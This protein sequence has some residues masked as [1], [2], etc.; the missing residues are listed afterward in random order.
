MN[1]EFISALHEIEKE[2]GISVD[3][4]IEALEAAL[5]SAYKKNFSTPQGVRV[6]IDRHKGDI[7]V[8]AQTQIVEEVSDERMEIS[9]EEAQKIDPNYQLGDVLENEVTPGDFGRIAAQTAKQVVVQRIREAERNIVYEDFMNRTSDII[10]GIVRRLENGNVFIDFGKAEGMLPLAEQINKERYHIGE[11]IKVYIVDVKKTNKGPQIIISRTHPGLIKRLFELEVPEIHDGTVEV[12]SVSREPGARSKIAVYAENENVDA[13][14]ACVG[15]RGSRVQR[16]V[17]EL[18]GEKIDIIDWEED[19]KDFIA[20][21][22]SPSTVEEVFL[23]ETLKAARAVVPDNQLSL[24]IGKEGQNVRLAAK[25]TGWKIDIKSQSQMEAFIEE[26][27]VPIILSPAPSAAAEEETGEETGEK[28]G[29]AIDK[30]TGLDLEEG[31]EAP[32][33]EGQDEKAAS[34]D[35]PEEEPG[36]SL[37]ALMEEDDSFFEEILEDLSEEKEAGDEDEK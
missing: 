18:S 9:L 1:K 26:H 10:N 20:N 33:E 30:E 32:L 37:S 36:L 27:G 34:Q 8:F 24:A 28:T 11:R 17:D 22:L 2:K 31:L 5:I 25:L 29:E 6:L 19:P 3:I 4:L 21:A 14:G 16:I 35:S 13:V 7:Q 23:D 12:K 15:P